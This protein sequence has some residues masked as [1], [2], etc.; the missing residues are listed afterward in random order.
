LL[1][2]SSAWLGDLLSHALIINKVNGT[3]WQLPGPSSLLLDETSYRSNCSRKCKRDRL[4]WWWHSRPDLKHWRILLRKIVSLKCDGDFVTACAV[5]RRRRNCRNH[6]RNYRCHR[7]HR[8]RH[9]HRHHYHHHHHHHHHHH[10][11]DCEGPPSWRLV[12]GLKP[13]VTLVN[14]EGVLKHVAEQ[15]LISR[16]NG[17]PTVL[18]SQSIQLF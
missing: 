6:R 14:P 3:I 4:N 7:R 11:M 17:L 8:R 12:L 5:L 1:P 9:R 13:R 16:L 10:L 15:A 18:D 2:Q